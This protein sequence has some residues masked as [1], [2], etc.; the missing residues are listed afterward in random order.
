MI[1]EQ[2]AQTLE[3][4]SE[5]DIVPETVLG[6]S[7][8]DDLLSR[9]FIVCSMLDPEDRNDYHPDGL[10]GVHLTTLGIDA[11]AE[12]HRANEEMRRQNAEKIEDR[13]YQELAQKR[14]F[15]HEWM[16]AIFSF[17]AGAITALVAEHFVEIVY[18]IQLFFA[19]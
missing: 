6:S 1:S 4:I 14:V 17:I 12:Y 9:G 8:V 2:T 15:R 19:E 5:K 11:L 7:L 18:C 3:M 13:N 10:H 16:I